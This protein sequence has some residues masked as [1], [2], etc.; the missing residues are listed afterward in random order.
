M[1]TVELFI[2][3]LYDFLDVF[4]K[5]IKIPTTLHHPRIILPV[6]KRLGLTH[7]CYKFSTL[8]NSTIIHKKCKTLPSPVRSE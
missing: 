2:F 4:R 6:D 5:I 1:D 3:K 7:N 8:T